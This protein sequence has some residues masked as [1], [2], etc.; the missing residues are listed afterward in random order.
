[1]EMLSLQTL[2]TPKDN[3]LDW[4]PAGPARFLRENVPAVRHRIAERLEAE[5]A[6][7]LV[8]SAACGVDQLVLDEAERLGLRRRI[9]IPFAPGRF[10]ESSVI[11]RPGN[12]G[13]MFDRFIVMAQE[14]ATTSCWMSMRVARRPMLR[15][16]RPSYAR[17]RRSLE[18]ALCT[19]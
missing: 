17:H 8:S 3:S 11:D 10:R 15:Q 19:G 1:M 12:W 13:P 9:I 18:M 4:Q 2:T 5:S 14:P 6:E 7:V 16:T